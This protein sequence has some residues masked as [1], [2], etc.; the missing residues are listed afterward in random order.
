[1]SKALASRVAVLENAL[2]TII[3]Q[4]PQTAPT[5]EDYDDTESA[6]NNGMDVGSWEQAQRASAALNGTGTA[7]ER[8]MVSLA[9]AK[10]REAR[11]LL[12]AAN[13]PRAT[14]RVRLALSSAEGAERNAGYREVRSLRTKQST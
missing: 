12:A 5:E 11:D 7:T 13:A 6:Y 9:I 2:K 14:E 4:A 10:L 3:A 8:D 1:M